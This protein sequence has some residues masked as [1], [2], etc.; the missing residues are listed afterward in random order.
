MLALCLL[1]FD[2]SEEGLELQD[3]L[4]PALELLLVVALLLHEQLRQFAVIV[5]LIIMHNRIRMLALLS[6]G[7]QLLVGSLCF[8]FLLLY[9]R[10]ELLLEY[11]AVTE[12][13]YGLGQLLLAMQLLLTQSLHILLE[14]LDIFCEA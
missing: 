7:G 12:L 14:M 9:L 13:Q 8:R 3:L 2:F 5:A 4:V 1:D 10:F 11:L 6:Q